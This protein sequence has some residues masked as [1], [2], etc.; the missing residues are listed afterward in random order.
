LEREFKQKIGI[1]PKQY[2]RIARLNGVQRLIENNTTQDFTNISYEGGY[3]DQAHFIREFKTFTGESPK[4]FVKK[5]KDFIVNNSLP[6]ST[7]HK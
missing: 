5:R 6:T 2:M 7:H 4:A 3:A 1:S